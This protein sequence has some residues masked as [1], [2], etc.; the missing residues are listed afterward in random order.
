MCKKLFC[1]IFLSVYLLFAKDV[2]TYGYCHF[3]YCRSELHW[4]FNRNGLATEA[5]NHPTTSSSSATSFSLIGR[6]LRT[7]IGYPIVRLQ[8]QGLYVL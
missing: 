1:E 8:M 3:D 2:F 6:S 4:G 5:N 7:R